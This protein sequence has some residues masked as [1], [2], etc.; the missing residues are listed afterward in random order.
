MLRSG[1]EEMIREKL[2]D[3]LKSYYIEVESIQAEIVKEKSALDVLRKEADAVFAAKRQAEQDVVSAQ[4]AVRSALDNAKKL[5]EEAMLSIANKVETANAKLAEGQKEAQLLQNRLSEKET[6]LGA[7]ADELRVKGDLLTEREQA[8]VSAEK[9]FD[10]RVRQLE[11]SRQQLNAGL[12][13]LSERVAECSAEQGALAV[14]KKALEDK[15]AELKLGFENLRAERVKLQSLEAKLNEVQ[16]GLRDLDA[17]KKAFEAVKIEYQEL[18]DKQLAR[19]ISLNEYEAR[20]E[21]DQ[22][23]LLERERLSNIKISGGN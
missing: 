2:V 22:E 18:R 5:E 21:V 20:L 13:D 9:A 4:E 3:G 16:A 19:E 10:E 17:E 6:L 15:E 23:D 12:K 1:N 8:L 11:A 14:Q 7:L